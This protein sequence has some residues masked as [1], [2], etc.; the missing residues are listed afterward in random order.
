MASSETE[1]QSA[2]SGADIPAGTAKQAVLEGQEPAPADHEVGAVAQAEA[3]AE[4]DEEQPPPDGGLLAW[5]QVLGSFFLFMNT[6]GIVNSYGVYQTYYQL[7]LLREQTPSQ[8]SWV[9][10]V[11]AFLLLVIGVATGPL[12][13]L[14]YFYWLLWTGS[15]L[16]VLGLMMTS[17][18]IVLG[19]GFGCLSVPSVAIIGTYFSSKK[20]FATGVATVG[21]SIGGV[22]YTLTFSRLWPRVGF[23]W[24]TRVV[25][26]LALAGLAVA[27][28]VMRVRVLP[29][30]VRRLL[31]PRAFL[32]L[33]YSAF[34]FAQFVGTMGIWV[35]FYYINS[36]AIQAAGVDPDF[37]F[38]LVAIMNSTSI[39]GRL[40][41][42]YFADRLGP[43]NIMA[44]AAACSAVLAF[45][46]IGIR[47]TPGLIVFCLLYGFTSGSFVSLPA[48]ALAALSP[49]L[50]VLGAR[51]GMSFS[52]TGIG[53]LIGNPIG[54][55]ILRN[56]GGSDGYGWVGLQ[57]WAGA[58][59]VA[60]SLAVLVARFAKNP[61]LLG[62]A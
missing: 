26:F 47:S 43:F 2:S 61:K 20:S 50:N 36:Y 41:P 8:I 22:I 42:N 58:N 4:P 38:Y 29:K 3:S 17:L 45:A 23:P 48:P 12:F 31:E 55:I 1:K 15:F 6:W 7:E 33:P 32:E 51:I 57:C 53:I 21:S 28:A 13:D 11:Q 62:K 10:S 49:S 54:G 59:I 56:T 35:P 30:S 40:L 52:L 27:C 46:W 34:T 16:V 37:A 9:G 19:L 24:A 39:L 60:S 5:L 44:P 14:G 18:C 25:G